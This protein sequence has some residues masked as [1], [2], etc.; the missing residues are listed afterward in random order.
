MAY[1]DTT[2]R[3]VIQGW[4]PDR[5]LL[6][7]DVLEGDLIGIDASNEWVLAKAAATAVLSMY[8]AGQ[9]GDDGDTITAFRRAVVRAEFDADAGEIGDV[10]YLSD[11]AGDSGTSAGSTTQVVGWISDTDRIELH[12]RNPLALDASDIANDAIDSQHYAAGSIDLEHMSVNSIDSDQYVDGSIDTAHIAADQID[13]TLIAD[14][15]IDSEHYTDG[16]IDTAH[17]AA[18]QIDS[19]LIADDAVDSEHYTDGSVD[20][21]HL[22]V[23]SPDGGLNALRCATAEYDFS[24]DGGTSGAI[25]L[26]VTIPDN[27]VI[28]GG[29]VDVITTCTS[30]TDA[31]TGA[32]HV[33]GAND[34]VTAVAIGTGTPWD[35]G[36]RDIIPDGTGTAQVKTTQARNITFTIAVE[37]F[38]AGR[39]F[40]YL[41]YLVSA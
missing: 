41:F 37:D 5:K 17:I 27:A 19:T 16:S 31:G 39:F 6:A 26:G 25:D 38:T 11:T 18:D 8:I 22:A 30:G 7:A 28:I 20:E 1:A 4:G 33:E 21:E 36:G 2:P 3:S 14:N 9:D 32:L 35:A 29:G 24:E 40:C 15:A 10:L 12:P 13:A 23:F 34:I